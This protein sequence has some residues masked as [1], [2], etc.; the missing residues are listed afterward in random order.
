[1]KYMDIIKRNRELGV[2]LTSAPYK[3]GVIS[4]ITVS[5][6][7]DILELSLREEGLNAQVVLGDYDSIVQDSV[8][9]ASFDAV[10]IFWESGNFVNGI[11]NRADS[12]SLAAYNEL[13]LRLEVEIA[14]VLNNL[15][16]T[17]LVLINK[18][19]S[20]L[21]DSDPL[22]H[23]ALF[24]LCHRLNSVVEQL[25]FKNN[26]VIDID[27]ILGILGHAKSVD[28]RQY[29]QSKSLYKL[30]FFKLYSSAI[31]PAFLS[32]CGRA[33]KILVLDCDNTL[34]GGVIGEDG[35]KGIVIADTDYKGKVFNEIQN[36]IKG[37]HNEGVLL[38]LCS[39]NNAQDVDNVF[40]SHPEMI[41]KK[42]DLISKK[43]NWN[44][45]ASNIKEISLELNIGLDSFVFI[46]DSP[47]EIGLIREAL[48]E[49]SCFQVPENLS[50]YPALV[51]KIKPLFF[52]LSVSEEDTKKT[53][54]YQ[55]DQ[56]RKVASKSFISVEEYLSS[57][58]LK[59]HVESGWDIPIPRVAQ[60]TQKTNQFNLTTKRYT[61][62]EIEV[63]QASGSFEIYSFELGDRYGNYGT[64]GVAIIRLDKLSGSAIIDT[65]L[66]SCRVIG[67][68]VEF[69][70]FN[71]I[72]KMLK[73][74]KINTLEASY[75]QTH[76]NNQVC[77]FYENLGFEFTSG[78]KEIKNYN[79]RL[80][81]FEPKKI[82]Y[83][84]EI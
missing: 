46:D 78:G 16:S 40:K 31:K 45:K 21:F 7:M 14:L 25:K 66:M 72:I 13:A 20:K 63:M 58:D 39:K 2:Q 76:K 75:I 62:V 24:N 69:Q 53:K 41:L 82:Q 73:E 36:I 9:F 34:W 43:I 17:P 48:P 26:I 5:H 70:F 42:D 56:D 32:I 23:S 51:R 18:F 81:G 79:L 22:R 61:E 59:I 28:Y 30:D 55:Q 1:M 27:Q 60:L 29:Q 10:I 84:S 19:S 77:D 64:T 3:I 52:N 38:A 71:K 37:L 12:L 11:H 83:I 54:L 57:L 15:K 8:K 80:H 65:F 4:N 6:I 47:F 35:L 49:V 44:D 74:I 68:N 33:K 67:R 50:E